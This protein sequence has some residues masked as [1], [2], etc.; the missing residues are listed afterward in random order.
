MSTQPRSEQ[1]AS[2][3]PPRLP[4]PPDAYNA[5]HIVQILNALRLFFN[6]VTAFMR[7]LTD[8]TGGGKLA[9]PYLSAYMLTTQTAAAA[10]TAYRVALDSVRFANGG[11]VLVGDGLHVECSG[12]YAVQ[13]TLHM[14][15]AS[16]SEHD[17]AFWLRK[18]S[19]G[20]T[21]LDLAETTREFTVSAKH[22]SADGQLAASCVF[23]V[24][25]LAGE[26]IE[27]WWSTTSTDVRLNSTATYTSPVRPSSPAATVSLQFVSALPA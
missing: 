13:C 25:L 3:A 23:F 5:S 12:L 4:D 15:N 8:P 21:A 27:C 16:S 19:N 14:H 20:G 1:L 6:Q 17:T 9:F 18:G 10:N 11:T 26:F 24:D 2:P 7:A 22:G